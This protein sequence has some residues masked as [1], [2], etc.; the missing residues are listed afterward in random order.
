ALTITVSS[1]SAPRG[2]DCA[3]EQHS[4]TPRAKVSDGPRSSAGRVCDPAPRGSRASRML[5]VR[6]KLACSTPA[7]GSERVDLLL[8]ARGP[9]DSV[10]GLL[11]KNS[12]AAPFSDRGNAATHR[13]HGARSSGG[14]GAVGQPRQSG[15]QSSSSLSGVASRPGNSPGM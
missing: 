15:S 5:L 3:A 12:L 2:A 14:A 13:D 9:P 1:A 10:P 6:P 4:Q 11:Q 7:P 8:S